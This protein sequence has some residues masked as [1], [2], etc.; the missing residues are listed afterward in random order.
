MKTLIRLVSLSTAVLMSPLSALAQSDPTFGLMNG[1]AL[2]RLLESSDAGE[3]FLGG[4]YVFGVV[5]SLIL[6]GK[7]CPPKSINGKQVADMVRHYLAENPDQ[8]DTTAASNAA[9]PLL[10]A[11]SCR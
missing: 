4:F 5:D 6:T 2:Y 9:V 1:N 10:R 11:W 8:R 7:V 3:K